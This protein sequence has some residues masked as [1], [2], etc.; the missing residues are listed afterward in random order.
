MAVRN[1][2]GKEVSTDEYSDRAT[3][4]AKWE[5]FEAEL[6][7]PGHLKVRNLSYGAE[8][9]SEHTYIVAVSNGSTDHCTCPA[10]E[11][12][13][14]PCKHRRFC[15]GHDALMLAAN[16][17]ESEVRSARSDLT[18]D[19]ERRTLPESNPWAGLEIE[20]CCRCGIEREVGKINPFGACSG[21]G[22]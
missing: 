1:A 17:S 8:E 9:A 22:D 10:D 15:E 6:G 2:N 7:A 12:R 18:H 16:A 4:R 13:S 19:L 21:G 11:H 14:E 3:L 20:H 5:D